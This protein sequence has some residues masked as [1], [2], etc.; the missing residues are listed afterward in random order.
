ML[1][2]ARVE[3]CEAEHRIIL[4]NEMLGQAFLDSDFPVHQTMANVL[5]KMTN[6]EACSER[7][8]CRHKLVDSRIRANLS[9]E[10]LNDTVFVRYSFETILKTLQ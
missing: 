10:R 5:L 1:P 3:Q 9:A 7:A 2:P 8:F 6:F 4:Y